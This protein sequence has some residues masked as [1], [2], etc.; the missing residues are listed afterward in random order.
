MALTL[1][2]DTTAVLRLDD[3]LDRVEA[4]VDLRDPD[5][6]AASAP[7]LRELANDR[8]L[9]VNRLNRY[10]EESFSGRDY[11]SAQAI[12][13][14]RRKDFYVRANLWPSTRDVA[15]ARIYQD[16]FSYNLAHDHNF[17][18]L[19]VSYLG[20]GYET[21]IYEY[22][23]ETVVGYVGEPV[24]IRFLERVKFQQGMVMMY[25][26]SRDLHVQYPPVDLTVSLNLLIAPPETCLREQYHFDLER[27]VI[28]ALP[29]ELE[30]SER[31][32]FVRMA[33]Q[34]GDA[35]SQ[36]LLADLAARHP[37]R[38]TRIA[39]S[40]ALA[41]LRPQEAQAIWERAA[42]DLSPLVQREARQV[43]AALAA[44]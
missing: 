26:A 32:S 2:C 13:L 27:K 12:L 30:A 34:I 6:I 44:A 33:G 7:W 17:N 24:E 20:P 4:E 35:N 42:A 36:Q 15:T 10:V 8:S 28:A 18:F 19:T 43:L 14:G 3:Y 38:R 40:E 5:S 25:R 41:R 23:P 11:G 37:C 29:P 16:Q 22:D 31:V 1:L 9:V 39:A 21:D